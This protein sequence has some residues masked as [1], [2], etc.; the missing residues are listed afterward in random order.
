MK[1]IP[2]S[3]SIDG[4]LA[5]YQHHLQGNAGLTSGTCTVRTF[6]VRTFLNALFRSRP[7]AVNLQ[8]LTAKALLDYILSA[9]ERWCSATVQSMA[10]G[11]RSFCR[12]LCVSGRTRCDLSRAIPAVC[13]ARDQFPTA[14]SHQELDRLL[15]TCRISRLAEGRDYAVLLCL[16][17]L[18]LRACEVAQLRLEDLEWRSST[19]RLCAT[20]GRRERRL[21]FTSEVGHALAKYLRQRRPTTTTRSVFVSLAS[22]Q[23][24]SADAISAI[25]GRAFR[26]ARISGRRGAHRLRH[27]VASH[28]VQRG[29]SLKAV[30]DLLGH[31]DL[32]TTQIYAKVNLPLLRA[33]AMPWPREAQP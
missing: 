27:T 4:L 6:Y 14:L 21:P 12:F 22:G 28:L 32:A 16:T 33:V 1:T 10:A 30:A 19:L 2:L 24:L 31:G 15:E 11:L 13:S 23:P 25:V 9:K 7:R 26:R 18:G 8:K 17:R 5:E 29:V 3:T 20:K